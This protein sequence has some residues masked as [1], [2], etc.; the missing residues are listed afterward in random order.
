VKEKRTMVEA[1]DHA[2]LERLQ[3]DNARLRAEADAL[4]HAL[5][6]GDEALATSEIRLKLAYLA[7]IQA[8]VRAIEAKDPYTVGHSGMVAKVA[9][10]I[11][12]QLAMSDDERERLRIAGTL[13]AIGKI[14]IDKKILIKEGALSPDERKALE[15]HVEIGTQI[16]EPVLY[17]W[18]VASLINQ[19]HERLDGSGYPRGLRGDEIEF[20]ARVLGLADAFVAM[21]ANRA[22]RKAYSE[23]D[24]LDYF[25]EEAGKTFDEACVAALAQLLGGDQELREEIDRFKTAT[26]RLSVK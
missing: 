5:D 19:A 25:Y 24:V 18:D 26:L 17:P 10:A 23:K 21:I 2:T 9:V 4:R 22:Y 16:V 8:L 13:M 12:R 20:E 6:R 11:G 3:R 15:R 7:T 14:G 1:N